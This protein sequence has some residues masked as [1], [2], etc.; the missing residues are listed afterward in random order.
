MKARAKTAPLNRFSARR[1][2]PE[3]IGIPSPT[4]SPRMS[5][6]RPLSSTRKPF[7]Q[8]VIPLKNQ[9]DE[10][11]ISF[12]SFSQETSI[13]YAA[14]FL[15]AQFQRFSRAFNLFTDTAASLFNSVYPDNTKRMKI[16]NSAIVV[17]S[18]QMMNEWIDFQKFFV[19]IKASNIVP[20]YKLISNS[21]TSLHQAIHDC[22]ELCGVGTRFPTLP[23]RFLNYVENELKKLNKEALL[24]F[25]ERVSEF[26]PLDYFD[27]C[28]EFVKNT[29]VTLL[30][31]IFQN[32]MATADVMRRKM[33]LNVAYDDLIKNL[34]ATQSF[35]SL[36]KDLE[37]Q[38]ILMNK[39][40]GDIYQILKM[41]V[42][43]RKV[44][45]VRDEVGTSLNMAIMRPKMRLDK[46]AAVN[47][48]VERADVIKA[49]I[50]RVEN[51]IKKKKEA[52]HEK[53]GNNTE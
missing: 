46:K 41:P 39:E 22:Y 3:L 53:E 28:K 25:N 4:L 52:N 15:V 50:V 27:R 1:Y 10:L 36:A 31:S 11:I 29:H 42:N 24:V 26:D 48:S 6:S 5:T 34:N 18:R 13:N 43:M 16:S 45:N 40:I 12:D 8:P 9:Y 14:P 17:Q 21:L 44:E 32:R 2:G 37:N 51:E 20:I 38:I 47:E 7:S 30:N 33:A 19:Q 49:Q 23:K 35:D